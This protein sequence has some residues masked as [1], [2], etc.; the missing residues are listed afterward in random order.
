[1][2]SRWKRARISREGA[3]AA[4]RAGKGIVLA[5]FIGT[6]GWPAASAEAAIVV[7]GNRA[8][9]DEQIVK[10]AG[11]GSGK[12]LDGAVRRIQSAY[13]ERGYLAAEVAVERSAVDST[14][15]LIV[16]EGEPARYGRV[17]VT[18]ARLVEDGKIGDLFGVKSGDRFVPQVLRSGF[19]RVLEHY[20]ANGYPFA[21]VWVDSVAIDES[22]NHVDV[23]LVV[24]EGGRETIGRVEFEGLEHTKEAVAVKLSG[25]KSGEPYDGGKLQAA[26]LRLSGSGVFDEVG[27]PVV[28]LSSDGAGVETLIRV[29][30]PKGRNSV[31][32]ALGYADRQG[33]EDRVLS[34]LVRVDLTN[35]GGS[36]K[37]LHVLWKNDGQGRGETR[38]SFRDR[39]FLGSRFG[40]G[41][42][43]EQ[44][45]LDTVYT[46]QSAGLEASAPVGR[47]GGGLL[48]VDAGT[49]GDRNTFSQGDV[50]NTMRLRLAAGVSY[51]SGREDRGGFVDFRTRHTYARKS[52][53]PRAGG[54]E[55]DVSQYIF[56]LQ[57]RAVDDLFGSFHGAMELVYRGIES[58]EAFVPLP[59]QFYVGGA[60]T[61]R[62]YRENQYHGRRVAYVRSEV[63]VGKS[64]RENGYLFVDGGYVLQ[65]TEGSSGDVSKEEIFP[66]GY[67][68]GVRTQ[69]RA[70]NIDLSFG[71]G[72]DPSLRATKVHVIL[73]RTF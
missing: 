9:S 38:L 48:G 65:E 41:V 58:D 68:F 57:T 45:G 52:I 23:S 37:D 10:L 25:L 54:A 33:T 27:Y 6:A 66:V 61:V 63:R 4:N 8:L 71:V 30:E 64:R 29:V 43:L 46:W 12:D 42:A 44:V 60:S 35:I 15:V 47:L 56:E 50:S 40:V 1:M 59:E 39:F 51:A 34:G 13:I 14:V 67:G 31:S 21:Q 5:L 26:R 53:R 20:D 73:N 19:L 7:R 36:L 72:D 16:E 62:G 55:V 32:G 24:V 28:R 2:N 17:S 18:G 70:G 49:Y 3:R 11:G 69:S 22:T